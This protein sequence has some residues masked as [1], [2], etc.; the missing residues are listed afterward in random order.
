MKK[1][2]IVCASILLIGCAHKPVEKYVAP[3][4][5][6]VRTSVEKVRKYVRPEGTAAVQELTSA[7]S[8][9]EFQVAEQAKSLAK[10]EADAVYWNQKHGEALRKLWFWRGLAILGA[11]LILA[12]VGLKTGWKFMV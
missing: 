5:V 9:Y 3:S 6:P 2:L 8:T 1:L 11:A 4:I 12:G 7:I 10:A